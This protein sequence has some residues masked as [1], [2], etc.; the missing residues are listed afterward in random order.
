MFKGIFLP[1]IIFT[2]IIC[3]PQ[4]LHVGIFKSP[5]L[6]TA[7]NP[8]AGFRLNPPVQILPCNPQGRSI[9]GRFPPNKALT[10]DPQCIFLC[11]KIYAHKYCTAHQNQFAF[12][13]EQS[14]GIESTISASKQNLS[15]S[16]ILYPVSFPSSIVNNIP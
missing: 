16:P 3:A 11:H 6:V 7:C 13:L 15:M 5:L 2:Q 8:L 4:L 14:S 9:W 12:S 1:L 10:L